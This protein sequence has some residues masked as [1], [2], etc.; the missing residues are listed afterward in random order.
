MTLTRYV[1]S[2][3]FEATKGT[4]QRGDIALDGVRIM[5]KTSG[6]SLELSNGHHALTNK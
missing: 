4:D 2:V 6:Q 5:P 1:K 3:V